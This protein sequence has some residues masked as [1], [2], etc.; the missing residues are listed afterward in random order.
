MFQTVHKHVSANEV[1]AAGKARMHMI[2]GD[3]NARF[4]PDL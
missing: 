1:T 3:L 2:K 4:R